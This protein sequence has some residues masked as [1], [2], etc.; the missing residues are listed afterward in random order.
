MQNQ[1]MALGLGAAEA[2]Q[3]AALPK[4]NSGAILA[5][6]KA[7]GPL[8]ARMLEVLLP[9]FVKDPAALAMFQ[10]LIEKWLASGGLPTPALIP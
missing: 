1:L 4:L 2:G 7:H 8:A 6:L 3:L 5:W 10:A 9:L